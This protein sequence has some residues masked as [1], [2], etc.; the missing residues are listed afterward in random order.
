MNSV[1]MYFVLH[2]S[3][4][5]EVRKFGEKAVDRC[6]AVDDLDTGDQ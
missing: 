5:N 6:A 3:G 2:S 1:V 4:A